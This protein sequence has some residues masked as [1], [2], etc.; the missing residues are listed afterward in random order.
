MTIT[1]KYEFETIAYSTTGWNG[2][3]TTFIEGVEAHLHSRMYREAAEAISAYDAVYVTNA[4]TYGKAQAD[5]SKMPA[6]G[7]AIEAVNPGE[8]FRVHR[9]GPITNSGWNWIIRKPVWLSPTVAGGLTQHRPASNAQLVG[10]PDSSTR[11]IL[12]GLVNLDGL[13]SWPTTTTTTE[14]TTTTT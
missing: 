8:D 9:E 12:G 4:G 2:V 6:L 13:G 10:I 5:G 11:L 3:L 7:I 14:S 1:D